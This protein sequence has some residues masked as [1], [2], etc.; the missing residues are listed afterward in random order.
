MLKA[1][2]G[3]TVRDALDFLARSDQELYVVPN[4]SY[5][6]LGTS[7]FVPIHGSA[8][9]YSTVADTICRVV[10]YD[11][12]SDR[13]IAAERGDPAF[14]EHV[15]N[16]QSR[17]VLLRLYIRVKAK[18]RYFVHRETL[19]NAS[20]LEL[21]TALHDRARHECRDPSIARR[22]RQGHR[23]QVLHGSRRHGFARA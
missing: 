22:Q 13:I 5:V 12:D 21:L 1:D 15:Y 4:Y 23:L 9:D 3:A 18:S 16:Q 14:R 17:V 8:V 7:F 2:S 11:P 19:T 6:S 20:A 10:L